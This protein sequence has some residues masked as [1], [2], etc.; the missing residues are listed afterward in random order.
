MSVL[1]FI[2]QSVW[3]FFGSIVLIADL[4]EAIADV[5]KAFR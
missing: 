4:G 3:H 2:F 1:A 5:I